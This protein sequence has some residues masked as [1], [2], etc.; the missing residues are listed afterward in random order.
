[1]SS[2]WIIFIN[3]FSQLFKGCFFYP[4]P[5]IFGAGF[6]HSQSVEDWLRVVYN[7]SIVGKSGKE[8]IFPL[9]VYNFV[10]YRLI[11]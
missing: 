2:E 5:K 3:G 8:W 11:N 1:V 9:V 10:K 4:A 6:I 7:K